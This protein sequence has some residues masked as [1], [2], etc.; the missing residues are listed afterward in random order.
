[1]CFEL[2][3]I[4]ERA[5][6]GGD[7]PENLIVLCPNCHQHRIHR[8]HEITA[9][10]LRLYKLRL[11]EENEIG[12]RLRLHTEELKRELAAAKVE[13]D[14]VP[15]PAMNAILGDM[16]GTRDPTD[17]FQVD[18]PHWTP[19]KKVHGRPIAAELYA[20]VYELD[21]RG[22]F[23]A[24]VIERLSEDVSRLNT[25]TLRAV[26]RERYEL[27]T[28]AAILDCLGPFKSREEA[29]SRAEQWAPRE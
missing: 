25:P 19:S 12:A 29:R 20:R 18:V 2:H 21:G 16:L 3:H 15:S 1:M 24:L 13:R 6:G 28:D 9:D 4:V 17:V 22:Q 26:L 7:E 10:Q 27:Y 5:N 23:V 11:L 8:S 14:Q